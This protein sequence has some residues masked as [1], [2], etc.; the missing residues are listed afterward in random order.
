M[1]RERVEHRVGGRVVRL[2]WRSEQRRCG[3][4]QQ[5]L[6]VCLERQ[7]PAQVVQA[8]HLRAVGLREM[9]LGQSRQHAVREHS[10]E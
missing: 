7:R 5:E 2:A 6:R 3:R 8:M 1:G 10:R 9:L 4:V